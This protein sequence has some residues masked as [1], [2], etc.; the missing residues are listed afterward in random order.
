MVK[1]KMLKSYFHNNKS[2]AENK[3][4]K[5]SIPI[6]HVSQ[7]INVDINILLNRIRINKKSEIKKKIIFYSLTILAVGLFSTLVV[8]MN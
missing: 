8:I 1:L 6:Q 3:S 4:Q 2:I 5:K 7:K